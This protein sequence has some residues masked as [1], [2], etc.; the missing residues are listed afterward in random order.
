MKVVI[1]GGRNYALTVYDEAALEGLHRCYGWTE[2]VHGGATGADTGAGAWAARQGLPV[3][4]LSAQWA[5]YGKAAGPLRNKAM[6]QYVG[7]DGMCVA[8][9]GGVGTADMIQ[10]AHANGLRVVDWR[11]GV[12]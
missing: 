1:A 4:M 9:P 8:F 6:A 12:S 11:K 3:T 2:V 7:P 10:K 5:Q